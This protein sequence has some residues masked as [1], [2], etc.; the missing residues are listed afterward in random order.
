MCLY[1]HNSLNFKKLDSVSVCKDHIETLFVKI[2]S[3]SEPTVIGVVYRPPNCNLEHF[4]K[5]Y[6]RILDELNGSSVY[7]LGDFNI[8]ILKNPTEL[9]DSFQEILYSNG[10]TPTISLP[11]HQMPSCAKTCIDNIHTN[12]M[13]DTTKSGVIIDNFSHHRLIFLL[14]EILPNKS[15]TFMYKAAQLWNEIHKQ[16]VPT[17]KGL[18]VSINSIKAKTKAILLEA[19]SSHF[20]DR[21]TEHNFQIPSATTTNISHL[22]P[23]NNDFVDVVAG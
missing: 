2:T 6:E 23:S 21:W 1:I 19:Q 16:I 14:R 11:T 18:T 5:E 7:I 4:N 13:N 17:D 15:N 12:I 22:K 8:D 10:L 3:S 20:T 9:E